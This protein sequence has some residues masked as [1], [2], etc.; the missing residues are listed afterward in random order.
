MTTTRTVFN[1]LNKRRQELYL[2]RPAIGEYVKKFV[3]YWA[4]VQALD[5]VGDILEQEETN[6]DIHSDPRPDSKLLGGDPEGRD[7]GNSKG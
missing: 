4:V 6:E 7:E 1:Y 5:I 3:E 2:S